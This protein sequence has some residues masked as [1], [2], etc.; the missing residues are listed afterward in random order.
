MS[1]QEQAYWE[2]SKQ[3]YANQLGGVT[4]PADRLNEIVEISVGFQPLGI[5]GSPRDDGDQ[6]AIASYFHPAIF[7]AH[8]WHDDGL[9]FEVEWIRRVNHGIQ[10]VRLFPDVSQPSFANRADTVNFDEKGNLWVTRN[11]ERDFYILSPPASKEKGRWT[12][13]NKVTLPIQESGY[14]GINS[15]LLADNLI[16]TIES[17]GDLKRWSICVYGREDLGLKSRV[18]SKPWRYGLALRG[19]STVPCTVTDFRSRERHGIYRGKLLVVPNVE[20][21]GIYFLSDGSA[22]VTR[23]GE[24]HPS[25]LGIPGALLYVPA[26]FFEK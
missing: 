8:V 25:P 4:I 19:R 17:A 20:G 2:A 14:E 16:L 1:T 12:L 26:R 9:H 18:S 11:S 15:A 10:S 5:C 23:Y 22:L 13:T 7:T 3:S 24:S 6:V 21:N